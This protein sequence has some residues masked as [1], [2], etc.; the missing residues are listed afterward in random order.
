MARPRRPTLQF[1]AL[2]RESRADLFAYVVSV[3]GDRATAEDVVAISFERAYSKRRAFNP[4]RGTPRQWLFGIARNAAL[5]E[6]RKRSR[7]ATPVADAGMHVADGA[8]AHDAAGDERA[9]AIRAAIGGLHP[10]DRE[11]I[12]LKF[13]AGLSNEEIAGTLGIT[14]GN[15]RVRMHRALTALREACA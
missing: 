8:H 11:L 4:S 15:A 12:A 2:Y 3:V 6:L 5:D 14:E 7:R 10:R 1:D 13:F 9:D